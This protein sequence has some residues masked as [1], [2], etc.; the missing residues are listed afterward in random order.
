M[1]T[2]PNGILTADFDTTRNLVMLTVDGG[3][4]PAE[5]GVVDSITIT[6]SSP[7]EGTVPVRDIINRRAAGGWLIGSDNEAPMDSDITYTV[8]GYDQ[9]G[10]ELGSASVGVATTG[11]A[12]GVWLKAAGRAQLTARVPLRAVGDQSSDTQGGV[13]QI[14]NGGDAVAQFSGVD[15]IA[16]SLVLFARTTEQVAALESLLAQ[17]RTLLVQTGQPEEFQSGWWHVHSVSRQNPAQVWSNVFAGRVFTLSMTRTQA[18]AGAG[19]IF[20]G[21]TYETVRQS[22]ATYQDVLNQNPTYLDVQMG[23]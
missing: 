6:R 19:R 22:S 1:P 2:S 20:T 11:A 3:M 7:G 21:T 18:P 10:W 9:N 14:P 16:T 17:E 8:T 13:Y 15:A 12:W 4:W 23:A 5:L